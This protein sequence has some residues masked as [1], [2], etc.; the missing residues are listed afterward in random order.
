M[1]R[2]WAVFVHNVLLPWVCHGVAFD[3]LWGGCKILVPLP[4]NDPTIEPI[5]LISV[6]KES[7]KETDMI[8]SGVL[9]GKEQS[10]KGE[11]RKDG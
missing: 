9:I 7:R 5:S 1:Y 10:V 4:S 6:T 3:W 8:H 2:G 11:W